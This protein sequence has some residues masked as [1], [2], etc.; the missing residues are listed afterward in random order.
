MLFLPS[1]L[2]LDVVLVVALFLRPCMHSYISICIVPALTSAQSYGPSCFG[3]KGLTHGVDVGA[4]LGRWH[5]GLEVGQGSLI[6]V[7]WAMDLR[8]VSIE[9][10][11]CEAGDA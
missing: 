11:G 5:R 10:Y 8:R 1:F 4:S 7:A 9:A 2:H 6:S 3:S